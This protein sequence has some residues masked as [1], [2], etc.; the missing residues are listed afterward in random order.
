[1]KERDAKQN[2]C[3]LLLEFMSLEL[4]TDWMVLYWCCE[5]TGGCRAAVKTRQDRTGQ[6]T[7]KAQQVIFHFL[8]TTFCFIRLN[9]S[10]SIVLHSSLAKIFQSLSVFEFLDNCSHRRDD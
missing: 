8:G 3:L 7:S 10:V 9:A 5:F 1:M 2:L 4:K 6:D